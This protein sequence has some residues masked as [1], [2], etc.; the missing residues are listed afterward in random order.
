MDQLNLELALQFNLVDE[1][2]YLKFIDS[3]FEMLIG[4]GLG[5][6]QWLHS[7]FAHVISFIVR[8]FSHY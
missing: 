5:S 3:F 1:D 6:N 2:R 4:P 7:E 8:S